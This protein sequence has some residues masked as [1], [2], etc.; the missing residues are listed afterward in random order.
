MGPRPDLAPDP[1]LNREEMEALQHEVARVAAWSDDG[2]PEPKTL[3]PAWVAGRDDAEGTAS[4]SAGGDG[5]IIVGVDQGFRD[6]GERAVSAAV[7]VQDGQVVDRARAE[8]SVELPYIPGLLAFREAP[9]VLDA[10][11]GLSVDPDCLLVDGSGRIHFRQAGLATH[12]GVVLDR[13]AIGVA[14]SLLCGTPRRALP[15]DGLPAGARVA[16]EADGEVDGAEAP[17][18][19]Y[20]FQSRQFDGARHVNPLF[21]SPG[22]RV[23]A[24][25]AVDIVARCCAGWKLPEP[26]RLADRAAG[27]A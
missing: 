24:A 20:A 12:V 10:V 19:G 21:V 26:I 11:R 6:G 14:K 16:I 13:P 7:A 1:A 4:P 15:T 5:P 8:R 22:H 3:R 9:A 2:A 23:T 25:T 27:Q 18:I 17:V